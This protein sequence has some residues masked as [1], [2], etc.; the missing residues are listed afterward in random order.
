MQTWNLNEMAAPAGSRDPVVLNSGPEGRALMIR[1][2][3]G[4]ELGDHQVKE[5]AYVV[6]LEG[7]VRLGGGEGAVQAEAGT[8]ALYEP[9][10]RRT[11]ASPDG[12]RLLML[13]SPWPGEGHY[14]GGDSPGSG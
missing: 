11:I 7:R 14:R 2:E 6:V 1:L 8:L 12:A 5:Y 10:E 4:Q 9:D 3:P 13:L